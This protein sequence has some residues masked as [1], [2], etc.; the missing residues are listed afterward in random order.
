MQRK[1]ITIYLEVWDLL[2]AHSKKSGVSIIRLVSDFV[3]EGL[4]GK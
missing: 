4:N 2:K 1:H 3:R